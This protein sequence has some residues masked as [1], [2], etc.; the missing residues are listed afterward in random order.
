MT[1]SVTSGDTSEATVSPASLTFTTGN[2]A[3]TQEVTVSGLSDSDTADETLN[4]NLSASGGDYAGKTAT[5]AVTVTDDD[6]PSITVNFGAA[7]YSVAESDDADTADET[8]NEVTVTVTLSADPERSVTITLTKTNQGGATSSD[9][10]GVPDNLTFDSGDDERTFTFSATSDSVDDDGESVKLGFGATLPDGVT[11]GTPAEATVSITDDDVPSVTAS[12]GA[13]S[14]TV[15]EG[16]SVTV[17][18]TLSADPERT[19]TIPITKTNQ[20]GASNADY[21]GVPANLVFHAGDTSKT[22]DFSATQDTADD[23]G[24]S[25]KL[26]FGTLPTLVTAG[27]NTEAT[28]S[29]NDDDDPVQESVSVQV[30]FKAAAYALTEGGTAEIA[31]T[32]SADPE[33]SLSIPLTTNNG[34]GLTSGDYSGV[35]ASIVFASGDTEKS[36]T[37]TA[38]QDEDNEDNE[39]LTLGFGTLPDAVTTGTTTQAMVTILDSI[40][41]SFDANTYQAYEGG[42]GA[43][44]TVQLDRAPTLQIVIPVTASGSNG[45]TSADWTGAPTS[46][47]F[48]AGDN[49]A[50]FTLMAFDDDIE[51]D[52]ETV[53]LAFGTLPAGFTAGSPSSATVELMNTEQ[54]T[55]DTAVWCATVKFADYSNNDW[56][57]MGLV[58]HPEQDPWGIRS[59]LADDGFTYRSTDYRIG[60]I[61]TRPGVHPLIAPRPPGAIPETSVF[62]IRFG[63]VDGAGARRVEEDHYQD[64]TLYVAGIELQ[65]SDALVSNSSSFVWLS[66]EFHKLYEDW[67]EGDTHQIMIVETPLSERVEPPATPPSA[68]RYVRVTNLDGKLLAIWMEPLDDGN[69]AV[70][71]FKV[72]WK[73]GSGTWTT[74][75]VKPMSPIHTQETPLTE[76]TYQIAGLTNYQ[77]YK[78]RVIAVN[79]AGDSLPSEEHFG[80]PQQEWLDIVSNVVNG[81]T[82]TLTYGRALNEDSVPDK[83]MFSVLAN[84]GLREITAVAVSGR[85]VTLTLAKPVTAADTV[86]VRYLHPTEAGTTGIQDTSLNYASACEFGDPLSESDNQ[87]DQAL[88]PDLTA[89]FEGT[90]PTTHTG[91]GDEL[92]FRIRFSEPVR[93]DA[94]PSFAYLLDV[95]GGTVTSAWW[96]NRDT[97]N[98]QIILTPDD[99]HNVTITLPSGRA[100]DARGAPCASGKRRLTNSL[101]HTITGDD[102]E[103]GGRSVNSPPNAPATGKPVVQGT[104]KVGETLTADTSKIADDNGTENAV[105]AYQWSA[106]NTDIQDATGASYTLTENE[107]NRK[108]Q[109]SVSFTDDDGNSEALVSLATKAVEEEHV[110]TPANGLPAIT[111]D[112]TVGQTLT[113]DTSGIRDWDGMQNAVFTYQWLAGG[114]DIEG[115]AAPSYTLTEQEFDLAISVRVSFMDD[116]GSAEV[117]TSEETGAVIPASPPPAPANL[118]ATVNGNG[119]ITLTWDAPNDNTVTGYQIL[120][121]LPTEGQEELLV[122]VEN[123]GA[124]V[125]EYTDTSVTQGVKHVYRV[126][127]INAAGLSDRS[128]FARARP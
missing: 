44:V 109:V 86:E 120:R 54:P 101:E 111:G 83:E 123:T 28:V 47:T 94:G 70:T 41:V 16:D 90:M 3:S 122:Y 58:Y 29:I 76:T 113:A 60:Y 35:P 17:T 91:S 55:C 45:A 62:R 31:V 77:T 92:S 37:F 9:Y 82:I 121:R 51:D 10:S 128:N 57:E 4:V 61:G 96:L 30:S 84:R 52:G 23:N 49:S 114:T 71:D 8:E 34:T 79:S 80:M 12:F 46:L 67:D 127:A 115:A 50:N 72:Q 89:Q 73:Q 99:D 7:T 26:S 63:R 88:T 117:L 87:T 118:T 98:W 1:V 81:S 11:A 93:V 53:D 13:S 32:L 22:F 59:S 25:V 56:G 69:S 43:F 103:R 5:V 21:S 108:I 18:L 119:T 102:G 85:E 104:A 68:P 65:F 15:D 75:T 125:T 2:W 14:Y 38:V 74:T 112:T 24:E 78:V 66:E 6:D 33:R 95:E 39:I 107:K 40:R 105:F 36:F 116:A 124:T 19:V 97:T 100:C 48:N 20:G 27:T 106:G 42:A 126:K 110:N 64:W